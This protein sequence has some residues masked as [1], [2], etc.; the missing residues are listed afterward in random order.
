MRRDHLVHEQT[1]TVGIL[2]SAKQGNHGFPGRVVSRGPRPP[3][4]SG[5][6]ALIWMST[7]PYAHRSSHVRGL[8]IP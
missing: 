4:Q 5:A 8:A 6:L 7:P 1:V 2:R 3:S